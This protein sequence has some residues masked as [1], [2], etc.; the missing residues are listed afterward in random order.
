M[1]FFKI[2]VLEVPY[3]I[4]K[5]EETLKIEL[6]PKDFGGIFLNP[7]FIHNPVFVIDVLKKMSYQIK[8][9][10]SNPQVS[11]MVCLIGVDTDLQDIRQASYNYF[12]KQANPNQYSL[13]VSELNCFLDEGRYLLICSLQNSQPVN[14]IMRVVVNSYENS[15]SDHPQTFERQNSKTEKTFNIS[16]LEMKGA[17]A[18]FPFKQI[19]TDSWQ[20]GRHDGIKKNYS[21]SYS[22]FHTNPGV[23]VNFHEPTTL[24]FHL[25]SKGYV[26]H[27]ANVLQKG[28]QDQEPPSL[29]IYVL[30]INN[31]T[32]LQPMLEDVNPTSAAW[33]YWT[34]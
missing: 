6:T 3:H 12:L 22:A 31:M 29:A 11:S 17:D 32:D 13:G 10:F 23:I 16:R 25:Y 28:E 27:Y 4:I 7:R 9:E 5:Q 14:S 19:Y 20:P 18:R 24:R 26:D 15:L 2:D 8:L 30:K 34:R 1:S 21:N 33:G